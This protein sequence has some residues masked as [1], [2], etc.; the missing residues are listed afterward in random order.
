MKKIA[1]IFLALVMTVS[2]A[3]LSANASGKKYQ[4]I[5]VPAI[6]AKGLTVTVDSM[7]VIEK[8]GSIQVAITYT[9]SNN[10]AKKKLDEGS[11]KIFFKGGSGEP[12]YGGFGYLFPGDTLTRSYTWEFKK[13]KKPL[14]IEF[15]ADFF[16][17]KPTA[18][19]LKW[20]VATAT[21]AP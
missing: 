7:D 11:F 12:Q 1:A 18:K 5:S 15:D 2:L 10:T 14:V 21:T 3:G 6:S 13:K 17:K 19:G 8:T 9:L 16:S 20:K 4:E